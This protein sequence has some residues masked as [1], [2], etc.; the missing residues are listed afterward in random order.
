[1]TTDDF[2]VPAP[3]L[4]PSGAGQDGA[5]VE[6]S[7]AP[8]PGGN[9]RPR[10]RGKSLPAMPPAGGEA[11]PSVS[12]RVAGGRAQSPVPPMAG[13]TGAGEQV[14]KPPSRTAP[15]AAPTATGATAG[16]PSRGVS[17]TPAPEAPLPSQAPAT[18]GG[19]DGEGQYPASG[20]AGPLAGHAPAGG[21]ADDCAVPPAGGQP[22]GLRGKA[23]MD[24][25]R[26]EEVR[27]AKARLNQRGHRPA[28]VPGRKPGMVR[29]MPEG[30]GAA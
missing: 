10:A 6:E 4:P 28:K 17:G 26:A 25:V 20:N 3:E 8:A 5:E 11:R 19:R 21:D 27:Q 15:E 22:P 12:P 13:G 14:A 30:P 16:V 18:Q 9:S 2:K 29:R 7:L 1:M 24:A 23:A